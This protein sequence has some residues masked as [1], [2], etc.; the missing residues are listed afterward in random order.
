M[1]KPPKLSLESA[2]R[3]LRQQGFKPLYEKGK[4]VD[5]R[6][7]RGPVLTTAEVIVH[8]SSRVTVSYR[9]STNDGKTKRKRDSRE[10]SAA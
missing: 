10:D 4:L 8:P 5:W 9:S 7:V 1:K 2:A 6:R 3:D